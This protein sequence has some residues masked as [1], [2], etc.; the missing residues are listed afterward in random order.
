MVPVEIVDDIQKLATPLA[1]PLVAIIAIVV[2][3]KH[4]VIL[5]QTVARLHELTGKGGELASLTDKLTDIGSRLQDISGQF[6]SLMREA[7]DNKEMLETLSIR[8]QSAELERLAEQQTALDTERPALSIDEMFTEM[9]SAWQQVKSVI[10]NKA[11]G[12]GVVPYLM[13]T[14]GV[15]TT[16]KEMADKGAITQRSAELAVALSAQYQRFYRTSSPR[17]EWLTYQVY[18]SFLEAANETKKALERRAS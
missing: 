8:G 14:K 6:N 15:S 7:A 4:L 13:G 10:Q 2:L 12:A 18:N 11:R 3:R 5:A 16:V 9:E 1:W 17:E